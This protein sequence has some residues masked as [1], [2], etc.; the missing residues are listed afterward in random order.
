MALRGGLSHLRLGS[1]GGDLECGPLL[2]GELG[3]HKLLL[4]GLSLAS[5]TLVQI[6]T[7]FDIVVDLLQLVHGLTRHLVAREC[8]D[9]E[10]QVHVLDRDPELSHADVGM[11]GACHSPDPLRFIYRLFVLLDT[12]LTQL[13]P[14]PRIHQGFRQG[15]AIRHR[16]TEGEELVALLLNIVVILLIAEVIDTDATLAPILHLQVLG[17]SSL[18]HEGG[19]LELHLYLM[20]EVVL[21]LEKDVDGIHHLALLDILE[22]QQT[23]QLLQPAD[24]RSEVLHSHLLEVDSIDLSDGFLLLLHLVRGVVRRV[25]V[26]RLLLIELQI[27]VVV[28]L[29]VSR[30]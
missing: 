16:G 14:L 15:S 6:F 11:R 1:V 28:G 23:V 19:L 24:E 26:P 29:E 12:V 20:L 4:V 17:V 21:R 13:V 7:L 9:L 10:D 25:S 2:G 30:E 5:N 3:W 27:E 22:A 8:N 18:L